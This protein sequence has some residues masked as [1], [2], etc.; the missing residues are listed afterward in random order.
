MRKILFTFILLAL[1]PLTSIGA[2][3]K[4]Y[5]FIISGSWLHTMDAEANN[6]MSGADVGYKFTSTCGIQASGLLSDT[7]DNGHQWGAFL[8]IFASPEISDRLYLVPSLGFG[9]V[10][11]PF[12]AKDFDGKFASQLSVKLSYDVDSDFFC[13][14]ECKCVSA[15]CKDLQMFLVGVNV[16]LKF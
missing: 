12:N 11:G 13:A 4:D 16:G 9:A 3:E 7:S 1:L 14:L 2:Q 8:G 6:Q 10:G 5:K 15:D